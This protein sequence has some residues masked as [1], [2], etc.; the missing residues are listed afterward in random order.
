MAIANCSHSPDSNLGLLCLC[1]LNSSVPY[2]NVPCAQTCSVFLLCTIVQYVCG[3]CVNELCVCAVNTWCPCLEYPIL[4]SLPSRT[5]WSSAK[6]S[7]TEPF[8]LAGLGCDLG[9]CA[10]L[11]GR[12]FQLMILY[13]QRTSDPNCA[14]WVVQ[15]K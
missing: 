5:S 4:S 3:I 9:A 6:R 8:L 12:D 1:V 10:Y 2:V 13:G 11:S 7:H 15:S 14:D